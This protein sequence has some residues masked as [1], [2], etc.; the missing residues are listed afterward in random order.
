MQNI[1]MPVIYFGTVN[2]SN[3]KTKLVTV[4]IPFPHLAL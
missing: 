4:V 3:C 2:C 1:F